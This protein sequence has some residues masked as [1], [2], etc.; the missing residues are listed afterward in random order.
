MLELGVYCLE[1]CGPARVWLLGTLAI[2]STTLALLE[3]PYPACA[4]LLF[5]LYLGAALDL[6]LRRRQSQQ[7]KLLQQLAELF[8]GSTESTR[9][10]VDCAA[11]GLAGERLRSEVQFASRALLHMAEQTEQ[12]GEAQNQRVD[13]IAAASEQISQTLLHIE[14]LAEQAVL[15]FSQ[16]HQMSDSGSHDA[17][18][19]GSEMQGIQL[20]LGRSAEAISQLLS[21]TGAVERSMQLIQALSKQTQLLALNA[22]I[23]AARAGEH[24]R[25]FAVVAEEV[26]NLAQSTDSAALE[27]NTAVDAIAA[28]VAHVQSQV[29]EHRHLLENGCQQSSELANRLLQQADF[30]SASLQGFAVM[31]QALA[32]HSQASQSLNQ[33]LHGIGTAL[34]QQSASNHELH[35][36]TRYLTQLTGEPAR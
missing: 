22:S 11:Q 9:L 13:M 31:R 36:L 6:S 12:Q 28:S 27:I 23:E 33:Q 10:L 24:G 4:V 2:A 16:M 19:V 1:R 35:D 34:S 30:S 32:E 26:R 14:N 25:G 21:H 8:G 5:L 18:S 7:D 29:E 20:S 15:A 17:Q 3:R